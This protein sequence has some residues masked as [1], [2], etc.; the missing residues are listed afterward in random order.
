MIVVLRWVNCLWE[1]IYGYNFLS[2]GEMKCTKWFEY[3]RKMWF[4]C[5]CHIATCDKRCQRKRNSRVETVDAVAGESGTCFSSQQLARMR[6]F[7][8]RLALIIDMG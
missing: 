5:G 4:N 6:K 1:R 2:P 7:N 3:V 8:S